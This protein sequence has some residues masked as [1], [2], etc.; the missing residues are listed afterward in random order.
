MPVGALPHAAPL[1][2]DQSVRKSGIFPKAFFQH[3][4]RREGA[5]GG[6]ARHGSA[7]RFKL[8][9][10]ATGQRERAR[11]TSALQQNKQRGTT[12]RKCLTGRPLRGRTLPSGILLA[13]ILLSLCA[14]APARAEDQIKVAC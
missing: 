3:E 11:R 2:M 14:A 5:R 13:G 10:A 7:R 1:V 12:M 8:W 4:M 9:S 6:P